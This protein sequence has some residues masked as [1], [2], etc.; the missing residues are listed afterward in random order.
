MRWYPQGDPVEMQ[1]TLKAFSL[2]LTS[3]EA[4]AKSVLIPA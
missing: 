4:Y 1:E 3:V 2:V